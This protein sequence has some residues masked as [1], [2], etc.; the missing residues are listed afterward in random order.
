MHGDLKLGGRSFDARL[1]VG[2]EPIN[3]QGLRRGSD[4]QTKLI[5]RMTAEQ[6]IEAME[7]RSPN[8]WLEEDLRPAR[9]TRWSRPLSLIRF[10]K[11]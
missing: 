11:R 2:L 9:C 1:A 6:S 3:L 8:N 10:A 7:H 4:W 5:R